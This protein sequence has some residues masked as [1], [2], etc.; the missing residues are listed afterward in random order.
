M[1]LNGKNML[2]HKARKLFD[3]RG[4][5]FQKEIDAKENKQEI[6]VS[7]VTGKNYTKCIWAALSKKYVFEHS[8]N[9]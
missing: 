5:F 2:T 1:P 9:A 8:Q 3:F 4:D 6:N 7:L